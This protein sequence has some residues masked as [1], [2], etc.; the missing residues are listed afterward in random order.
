M[1]REKVLVAERSTFM[2]IMVTTALERLGFEVVGMAKDGEDAVTKYMELKPDIT[3]VDIGLEGIDGIE[4]TRRIV[5]ED[6]AA[7]VLIL[8]AESIDIPDIIVEAVRAGA[9]G[10]IKKPL[11]ETEI[12]KR[13]SGALGRS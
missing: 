11:S 8:I 2:R 10:Y 5:K 12:E 3:L 9:K 6:P 7:L 4:V 1:K 13:I